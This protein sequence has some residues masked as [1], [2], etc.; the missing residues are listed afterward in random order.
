MV[1]FYSRS[2]T[3]GEVKYLRARL[4]VWQ[5]VRRRALRSL[6]LLPLVPLL[7]V[8]LTVWLTE[9]WGGLT[10]VYGFLFVFL[11]FAIWIWTVIGTLG[12]TKQLLSRM[13]KTLSNEMNVVHCQSEQMISLEEIEDEGAEY[14]FQVDD[15]HLLFISGQDFYETSRFPNTDFEIVSCKAFFHIYCHG[16]KLQPLRVIDVEAKK[17]LV[18]VLPNHLAVSEG[19]LANLEEILTRR[20]DLAS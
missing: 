9:L 5:K 13:A 18:S 4:I 8:P 10:A 11:C 14:F 6:W 3:R 16:K 17:I 12:T 15:S 1:T 20:A 19:R 7:G 2:L